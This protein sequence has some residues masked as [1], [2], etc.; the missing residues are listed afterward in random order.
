MRTLA[1]LLLP[2]FFVFTTLAQSGENSAAL[3]KKGIAL[4]DKGDYAGAIKVYDEILKT[5]PE[6]TEVL[7][8]KSFSLV[9]QGSFQECA[10]LC[11]DILKRFPDNQYNKEV[12]V[13]YGTALDHLKKPEEAIKVYSD[14]IS[15]YPNHYLL[16]FNRGI[17]ESIIKQKDKA[18]AD[19]KSSVSLKPT[20]PTSHMYLSLLMTTSNKIAAM[21]SLSA[22]L[23]IEPT[24]QR[25]ERALPQLLNLA[26][27][28][29]T[30]KDEKN[31]TISLDSKLVDSTIKMEDDY[32]SAELAM[33]MLSALGMS[34][35]NKDNVAEKLS[36]T[37]STIVSIITERQKADNTTG[38]YTSFYL[39]FFKSLK[40][41]GYL[42][43][44]S[45]IICSSADEKDVKKWL[46]KNKGK[47]DEF[48][49]YMRDYKWTVPTY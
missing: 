43:T 36:E 10:D 32:R 41:E 5:E 3:L 37:L 28:N 26:G 9:Q 47:V 49:S 11:A 20:H 42:E 7:Y 25:A 27:S 34:K 19:F 45:Y 16:Y 18:I 31:I 15:K 2:L 29:V 24:G 12:Y 13:N 8:E 44:A 30:K 6:N 46:S 35:K 21:M 39:P 38:F 4:H 14:G 22:F 40:D 33:S 48:Y 23:I 1:A 17:T